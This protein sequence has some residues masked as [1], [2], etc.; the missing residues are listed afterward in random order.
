LLRVCSDQCSG[1]GGVLVRELVD[2]G[3]DP[4]PGVRAIVIAAGYHELVDADCPFLV[5]FVARLP[6]RRSAAVA[7]FC[8]SQYRRDR[9][10]WVDISIFA[11]KTPPVNFIGGKI[12]AD[13]NEIREAGSIRHHLR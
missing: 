11:E 8:R 6:R 4:V 5:G 9:L 13:P 10:S 2:G 12:R 3:R 7:H 1:P